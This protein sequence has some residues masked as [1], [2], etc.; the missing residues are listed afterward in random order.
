MQLKCFP[1]TTEDD[2][3]AC[4]AIRNVAFVDEQNVPAAIEADGL[5]PSARQ[6]GVRA[7]GQ[8]VGTCRVRL[9]GSAAKIERVAV[10]KDYRGKGVG[11]V[12]MKY[13]LNELRKNGDIH[14]FKLS[15]QAYAVPF[16][17]KLGFKTRGHEY[18][19]AGIPHYDMVLEK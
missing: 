8:L 5:D 9:I 15:S 17:E 1:V 11:R 16:Y 7:D 19:E 12:L 2:L 4:M 10:M 13:I 3:A 6:F 18:L 14:L